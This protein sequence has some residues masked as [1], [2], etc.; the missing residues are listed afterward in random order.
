M[1]CDKLQ[2]ICKSRLPFS[3]SESSDFVCRR[4][5]NVQLILKNSTSPE[6]ELKNKG[7][8]NALLFRLVKVF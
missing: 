2:V 3:M 4:N 7:C 5:K 8:K 6:I 1:I